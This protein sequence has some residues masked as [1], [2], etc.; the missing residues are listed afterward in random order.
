M[1]AIRLNDREAIVVAIPDDLDS[2]LQ[3]KLNETRARITHKQQMWAEYF[4]QV[5][6]PTGA[7]RLAGYGGGKDGK[8]YKQRGYSNTHNS[9][10]M[11]YVRALLTVIGAMSVDEVRARLEQ[12]ARGDIGNFLH[13]VTD[14]D[15]KTSLM[16][17]WEGAV[18]AGLT[19]LIKKYSN[20]PRGGVVV[21]LYDAQVALDRLARMQGMYK[22]GGIEQKVG[23]FVSIG[24]LDLEKDL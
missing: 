19:H 20:T 21:E 11:D 16:L 12:H 8:A 9:R 2:V 5:I 10:V 13:L 17:D 24:G 7:A 15:G 4:V 23:V 14:D 3:D 6:S 22:D 1:G 18:E